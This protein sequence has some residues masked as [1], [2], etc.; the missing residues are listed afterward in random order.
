MVTRYS[1]TIDSIAWLKALEV[2]LGSQI[3]E[4]DN[5]G[6]IPDVRGNGA[7]GFAGHNHSENVWRASE[8]R[9]QRPL[10]VG[11]IRFRGG[12]MLQD[13]EDNLV[14][15]DERSFKASRAEL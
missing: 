15:F 5:P 3:F 10:G 13:I 7:A 14:R 8:I 6:L 11:R 9:E 2:H 1:R 12:K 4:E